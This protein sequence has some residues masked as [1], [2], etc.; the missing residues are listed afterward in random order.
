MYQPVIISRTQQRRCSKLEAFFLDISKAFHKVWNKVLTCKSKKNGISG[1]LLHVFSDFL[2]NTNHWVV[3][4]GQSLSWTNV[5][6]GGLQ[7]SILRP[8]LFLIYINDFVDDLSSNVNIF[9]IVQAKKKCMFAVTWPSLLGSRDPKH[10]YAKICKNFKIPF[11][12][13]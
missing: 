9:S 5:C 13:F 3:L 12:N 4:N 8:L 6:T 7:G 1:N 2:S 11:K 10:F